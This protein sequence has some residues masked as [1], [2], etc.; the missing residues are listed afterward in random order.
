MPDITLDFYIFKDSSEENRHYSQKAVLLM[1]EG[2]VSV[3]RLWLR[4]NPN[5]PK[6]YNSG[7]VYM[8]ETVEEWRDIPTI[9]LNR[10]GDCEDLGCYRVAELRNEGVWCQP[11]LK[12]R[13]YGNFWLYH[14]Q[15]AHMETRK[16]RACIARIEDPSRVLGM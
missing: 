10:G 11:F 2:M 7:A 5:T 4:L 15:V 8:R 14:V 6:L 12:W 16:G 13:R 3:N 9:L 1:L